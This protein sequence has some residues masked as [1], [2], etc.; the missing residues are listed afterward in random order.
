MIST[1]NAGKSAAL[2]AGAHTITAA[3]TPTMRILWGIEHFIR[4]TIV[5]ND[6]SI[7]QLGD[8]GNRLFTSYSRSPGAAEGS[9]DCAPPNKSLGQESDY[10]FLI[11]NS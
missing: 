11:P 4:C 6:A 8:F 2:A 1:H 3:A 5:C 9:M 7:K 10:E